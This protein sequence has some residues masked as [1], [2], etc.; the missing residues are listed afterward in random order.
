MLKFSMPFLLTISLAT[1]SMAITINAAEQ[2]FSKSNIIEKGAKLQLLADGFSFTEGPASDGQ[3]N[4]YF[5]DQPNDRIMKWSIEGKLSTFLQPSGR[6]NGLCFDTS[7][8]LIACA[9]GKN[10]MWS[11]DPQGK[12]TVLFQRY[13]NKLLN[14]PNDVWLRPDGG[15]YFSDPFYKRPYWERGPQ[16]QSVMAVY[17]VSPDR[18]G[19]KR[20]IEDFMTP[21]GLVGTP[22]GKTLYVSDIKAKQT[23]RF[24]IGADG[25]LSDKTKFC[26]MGSDGMKV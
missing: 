13:D 18:S 7:G 1:A 19:L 9:D 24:T 20:V 4:I 5:T 2:D 6:S 14:G 12:H 8:N 26:D 21:N 15:L 22:D 16:E 25:T 10:E 3:G 11:I 23:W 17:Y